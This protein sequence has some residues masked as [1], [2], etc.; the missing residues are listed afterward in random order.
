MRCLDAITFFCFFRRMLIAAVVAC[1]AL[2]LAACDSSTKPGDGAAPPSTAQPARSVND[3]V[4]K[5]SLVTLLGEQVSITPPISML[6]QA[7]GTLS[8]RSAVN[9]YSGSLDKDRLPSGGF[10]IF[11]IASTMMAGTPERMELEA[12]YFRGLERAK[13]WGIENGELVLHEG[14]IEVARFKRASE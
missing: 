6:I 7:D 1:A 13:T 2:L 5:W 10:E 12:R 4:G 3:L 9:G 14:E 8:G 11:P